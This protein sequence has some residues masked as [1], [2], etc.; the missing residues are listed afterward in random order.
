[1]I[2]Q[3][4]KDLARY[5]DHTLL[6]CM[7]GQQDI[8]RVCEEAVQY[9]F[10]AVC[11][12]PRWV[13]LCADILRGSD[14]KIVSVA[15]F[16]FGTNLSK[17]KAYEA[18]AAIM[19]GADEVDMVA[20]LASIVAQDSAY[21]HRE[22]NAVLAVCR[23]MKPAVVLKVIIES[24]ALNREQ[25]HFV[26]RIAQEAGV[27]YIKTSTGFHKAGGARIEDVRLMAAAAPQCRIKAAGGIKTAQEALAFIEAG[28]A[29]IGSSSSVQILEQFNP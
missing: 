12:Q 1:M 10:Y 13:K 19:D 5:F 9:G 14:I 7:A 17:A 3:T 15:G 6:D 28:A 11:I 29:R 8:R 25:I 26:C 23:R 18:D 24:A 16:P 22:L 20:D 27:D 2:P 21:L 4:K